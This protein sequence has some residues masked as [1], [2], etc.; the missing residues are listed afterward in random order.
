MHEMSFVIILFPIQSAIHTLSQSRKGRDRSGKRVFLTAPQIYIGTIGHHINRPTCRQ[1][2]QS[3]DK[4]AS[5]GLVV[6]S[7]PVEKR[8]G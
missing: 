1:D 5:N 2:H 8:K 7:L 6:R 4:G 3:S